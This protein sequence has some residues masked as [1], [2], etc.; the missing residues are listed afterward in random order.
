MMLPVAGL[1]VVSGEG[2]D[3]VVNALVRRLSY[4]FTWLVVDR[5][6]GIIVGMR[7]IC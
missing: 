4:S 1:P 6:L 3:S 2:S 5:C 7:L